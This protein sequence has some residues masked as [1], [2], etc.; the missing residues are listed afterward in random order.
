VGQ[1]VSPP[2][3]ST[4]CKLLIIGYVSRVHRVDYRTR[5][6][7][8]ERRTEAFR[9]QMDDLTEAYLEWSHGR[10]APAGPVP[11]DSA[12]YSIRVVDTF[13]EL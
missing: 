13:G 6:D 12:E 5:R 9:L 1:I 7:R 4:F 3:Y 8:T 10:A 2:G 11:A